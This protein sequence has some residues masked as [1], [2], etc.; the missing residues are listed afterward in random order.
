MGMFL[1]KILSII[2][3]TYNAEDTI[4]KAIN[5][6][7]QATRLNEIELIITDDYSSD[8]TFSLLQDFSKKYECIKVFKTERNTGSPSIPRN[9]GIEKA[10]GKFIT[11]FDDD[12]FL[13]FNNLMNMVDYA[14]SNDLDFLH[15]YLKVIK[16]NEVLI[17]NKIPSVDKD[18]IIKDII[19]YQSTRTDVIIKN[20]FL[21]KHNI[22]FNPKYKLAEDTIFYSE[23]FL[24]NPKVDYIDN[25]F[26]YYV[27]SANPLNPS[28]TQDCSDL[29]I[30]NLIDAWQ[31]IKSNCDKIN[32]D[33]FDL[34]LPVA[35]RHLLYNIVSFSKGRVS[36]ITFNKLHSFTNTN[37]N[38]LK[39]QLNLHPRHQEV[40]NAIVSGDYLVFLEV[41]KLRLLINGYDLKFILPLVKHFSQLFNVKIE[42]WE[43]HDHKQGAKLLHWAD[44]I[45]CEWLLGN[46]VW[47]SKRKLSHHNLIIRAHRFERFRLF[48]SQV[49]YSKVDQ[50]VCVAYYYL[51]Q[52]IKQFNIPRYKASL[53]SNYIE[54]FNIKKEKDYKYNIAM[55]GILPKRKG[56][57][58]ALV[59]IKKLKS[60]DSKFKLNIIGQ[61][62]EIAPWVWNIQNERNYYDSC[63]DYIKNNEL[64]D[65]VIF[66]GYRKREDIYH[67]MGFTLSLSDD[68]SFH[69][70]IAESLA[71]DCFPLALNWPGIEYIYQDNIIHNSVDDIFNKIIHLFDNNLSREEVSRKERNFAITNYDIEKIYS[72]IIGLLTKLRLN[73]I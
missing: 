16:N 61:K 30:N 21:R 28:S 36:E 72:E 66:L 9:I 47:Y 43:G 33:Y 50:V 1:D 52:F 27:K 34:R 17:A 6:V 69:L 26:M 10:T 37:I 45:W 35:F 42:E 63:Y 29:E 3:A 13:D 48:G 5:S 46:A 12:D 44:I 59:L 70:S 41:T 64:T 24:H 4:C 22:Q 7:V 20:G 2:M 73:L 14:N 31:E 71:A 39:H 57:F 51:E 62:P 8:N 40:F 15:G 58:N 65:N 19:Q 54:Y 23:C 49:D 11:F 53:I 55:V 25:Y 18:N 68:E 56:F 38:Y 60:Y 67:N 32:I